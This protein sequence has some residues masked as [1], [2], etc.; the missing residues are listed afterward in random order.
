MSRFQR[1]AS[2]LG[3]VACIFLV[4]ACATQ[5]SKMV[6]IEQT[7]PIE[8]NYSGAKTPIVVSVFSN[9]SDYQK[10]VFSGD[11]DRL[12]QQALGILQAHLQSNNRFQVMNRD[13]LDTLEKEA[14]LTGQELG[15]KGAEFFVSG[16]INEFGR[17]VQGDKQL[18]GILGSGKKQIAYAKVSITVIDVKT[19]QVVVAVQGAA[20]YQLSN[21]EVI[22]FGG[23]AGYDSTL[24]G[25]VINLAVI[26]AINKLNLTWNPVK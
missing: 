26:D 14:S 1:F 16:S 4:S 22:G 19:S 2:R 3:L 12:G 20:E 10:G 21:R 25:K 17:T 7:V 11:T 6:A 8:D 24:T 18:F 5:S 15:L 23:T 13:N 9:R